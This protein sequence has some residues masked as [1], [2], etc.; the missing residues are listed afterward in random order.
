[1]A[2]TL[3][4]QQRLQRVSL[5]HLFEQKKELWT[6][7]ARNA[8]RY[9]KGIADRA[10]WTVRQDDVAPALAQALRVSVPLSEY[11]AQQKLKERYWVDW[12]AYLILD[13][14]WAEL[15]KLDKKERR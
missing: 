11:L 8:Y 4:Q 9:T 3:E 5:V 7:I 2:L 6:E 10:K 13:T 12:F 15:D 1:M 14:L